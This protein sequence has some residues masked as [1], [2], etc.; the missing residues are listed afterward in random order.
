MRLLPELVLS[1][2]YDTKANLTAD[3]NRSLTFDTDNLLTQA[4]IG[5]ST[6]NYTY[7]FA[8]R[9]A[10]RAQGSGS[11]R[12]IY[13]QEWN[14]LAE[15]DG[16]NGN[17]LVN[18]L[19]G[20]AIDD[21][22]AEVRSSGSQVD[23][24]LK[25]NIGSTV[26]TFRAGSSIQQRYTYDEYGT[27]QVRDSAGNTSSAAPVTRYLFTGREYDMTSGLYHYRHRWYHPGIGRFLSLDP[28]GLAGNDANIYNYAFSNPVLFY[29]P[30]GLDGL[31]NLVRDKAP[32]GQ[33]PRLQPG[34]LTVTENGREVA[35]C[36]ANENGFYSGTRG[37]PTGPYTV[38]RKVTDGNFP[39]G[40]PAITGPNQPPGRPGPGYQADATLIHSAGPAGGGPDSRA[41]I[42]VPRD[43]AD[44]IRAIMNRNLNNGGTRL[45]VR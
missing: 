42:T 44:L 27:I 20:P 6:V 36:R 23:Y 12:Y 32:K 39:A 35:R 10:K 31:I 45:N 15:L 2:T 38:E 13:D 33:D 18:Y 21:V 30:M 11:L 4:V 41:C 14:V 40:T 24:L 16:A 9:L 3:A 1:I 25:D 37:V 43:I 28:I 17:T 26:A 29:D 34:T 7:D 5:S 22:I 19:R 8:H